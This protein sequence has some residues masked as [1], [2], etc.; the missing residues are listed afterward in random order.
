MKTIP[1]PSQN[2]NHWLQNCNN[3]RI[4]NPSN[5]AGLKFKKKY[6]KHHNQPDLQL[7]AG[8]ISL[9]ENL[10]I[11]ASQQSKVCCSQSSGSEVPADRL[12]LLAGSATAATDDD[13]PE[14]VQ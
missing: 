1:V 2:C 3:T 14:V 4:L 12:C 11:M 5:S 8:E 9:S 7:L 13:Q 6:Q 10:L